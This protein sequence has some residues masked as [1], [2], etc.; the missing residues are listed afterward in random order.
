MLIIR[1]ICS[2]SRYFNLN[3]PILW[4]PY[5]RT[6]GQFWLNP[7]PVIIAGWICLYSLSIIWSIYDVEESICV[8]VL[9]M[10]RWEEVWIWYLVMFE[11]SMRC[12]NFCALMICLMSWGSWCSFGSEVYPSYIIGSFFLKILYFSIEPS[13]TGGNRKCIRG[14]GVY[15]GSTIFMKYPWYNVEYTLVVF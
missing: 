8:W 2:V 11:A 7:V 15:S 4:L 14:F 10:K 6:F 1:I 13:A 3:A 12:M 5:R 9:F